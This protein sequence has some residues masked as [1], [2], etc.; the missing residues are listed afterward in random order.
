MPGVTCYVADEE[1]CRSTRKPQAEVPPSPKF[2]ARSIVVATTPA[3]HR[4]SVSP[5]RTIAPASAPSHVSPTRWAGDQNVTRRPN[6]TMRIRRTFTARE[7]CYSGQNGISRTFPTCG[8][9][10]Y[11]RQDYNQ[12]VVALQN[13][14]AYEENTTRWDLWKGK[15]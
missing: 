6:R 10:C 9:S 14:Y 1:A 11:R 12:F 8:N 15:R 5:R 7:F 2:S 4:T 3:S 13:V